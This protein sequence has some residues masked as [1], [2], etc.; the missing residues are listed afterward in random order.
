MQFFIMVACI[1]ALCWKE[2]PV[3]VS[4]VNSQLSSH[5]GDFLRSRRVLLLSTSFCQC[6]AA[7]VAIAL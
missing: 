5:E 4:L 1:T 7:L 2:C 6:C 3:A